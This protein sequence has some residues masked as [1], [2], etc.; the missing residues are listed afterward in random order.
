MKRLLTFLF[1]ITPIIFFT[2]CQPYQP[3]GQGVIG[4]ITWVEGNQMPMIQ[5][6]EDIEKS[7]KKVE[8]TIYVYPLTN[9]SDVKV[10]EGLITSIATKKVK[11]VKTD[12][13]GKYA[14]DLSPGRYTLL[15]KEEN[16]MFASIFDGEGN[17]QPVTIKENE[18]TLVDIQINYKAFY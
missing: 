4:T 10:E 1:L 17:I 9:I 8:R 15:T 18:W 2:Q 14:I 12:G 6:G 5:D 3:E 11:E 7:A 16:G 13:S